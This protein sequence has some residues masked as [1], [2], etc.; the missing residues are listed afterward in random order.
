MRARILMA[1]LA[2]SAAVASAVPA[3]AD[4]PSLIRSTDVALAPSVFGPAAP[5][6]LF[7]KAQWAWGGRRYCFYE[8]GWRGP[9]YYWCGYN[10]RRGF[11]WGG[12]L[13]WNG[14]GRTY[15]RP[16]YREG[17]HGGRE[18]G[19]HRG[20]RG[21]RDWHGDRGAHGGWGGHDHGGHHR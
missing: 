16:G 12:P 7:K 17:W 11:G 21:D 19:E 15:V 4:A 1:G 6:G 14:W 9:G 18:W 3:S 2:A 5:D 8:Y 13:G 20:W 10:A